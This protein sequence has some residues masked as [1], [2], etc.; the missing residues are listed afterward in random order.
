MSTQLNSTLNTEKVK[1]FKTVETRNSNMEKSLAQGK[2]G[3]ALLKEVEG[4]VHYIDI[5]PGSTPGD[6]VVMD[7][8]D[9]LPGKL[10][11]LVCPE[12]TKEDLLSFFFD[13][14]RMLQSLPLSHFGQGCSIFEDDN[15]FVTGVIYH[16][17]RDLECIKPMIPHPLCTPLEQ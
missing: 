7:C 15:S 14:H 10:A 16:A 5:S 17:W 11:L 8:Y 6:L 4:R 13:V 2:H 12:V 1:K 3:E 9:P